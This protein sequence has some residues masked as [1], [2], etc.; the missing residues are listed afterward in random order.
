MMIALS[1]DRFIWDS[2]WDKAR[3]FVC[4]EANIAPFQ[5][6]QLVQIASAQLQ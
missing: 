3:D 4:R 2:L 1:S 5:F 6:N